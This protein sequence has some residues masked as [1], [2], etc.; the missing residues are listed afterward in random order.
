MTPGPG[1][2]GSRS[3]R[4]ERAPPAARSALVVWLWPAIVLVAGL[5]MAY[6]VAALQHRSEA[7]RRRSAVRAELEPMRGALGREIFAAIYLTQGI[8]SSIA[9][10]GGITD[11]KL[12]AL[13]SELLRRSDLVRNFAV[14]PGNVV[15]YVFPV[16]G[17][18]R[19]IGLDYATNAAQWPSVERMMRERALVMAGPVEL[20]QGGLG[21]IGRTPIYVRDPDGGPDARRYWGL[22]STVIDFEKLLARTPIPAAVD[23]LRIGLRGVDG[24][25]GRGEVFW[26]DAGVFDASPVVVDVPLPSGSWLLAAA[27]RGGWPPFRPLGSA[28]FL[29]GGALSAVVAALLLQILRVGAARRRAVTE[30]AES[31]RKAAALLRV[32]ADELERAVAERTAEL[33]VAKE[34]AESADHLKSAFLATMSHELRTPLNSIIGFSGLLLQR[35]PGPLNDEQ[36]KQLGMV[37]SSARHLLAL[38]NDVLDLSKIEAGQLGVVAAPFDARGSIEGVIETLRP[39][40]D[41]KGIALEVAISPEVG[42]ITS[43]QRRVEQVLL[44]LVSNAVKFTDRGRVRVEAERRDGVLAVRVSDTGIGIKAEQLDRLF[45]PFSQLDIGLGRLHDGTGLGLSICKRLVELL[46]GSIWVRSTW[47]QGSTFGFELPVDREAP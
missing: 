31:E 25:G 8:S 46:G 4:G 6:T 32:R 9:V 39:Q 28:Y 3:S 13:A 20:V 16:K 19:A 21:V 7:E 33:V 12:H 1:D 17:N 36:A 29:T 42:A 41:K 38:I 2:A 26:G 47:G 34:A 14:A 23:E 37:S 45:R 11:D 15:R 24:L 44:N 35:L 5:G 40:A 18:E 22:T 10:E 30:L 43:D 27:P